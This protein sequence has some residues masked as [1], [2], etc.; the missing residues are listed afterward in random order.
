MFELTETAPP[1]ELP[2]ARAALEAQLRLG[3]G[4][5]DPTGEGA[6]LDRVIAAATAALEARLGAAFVARGFRLRTDA[7]GPGGRL[8]L[9]VGPVAEIA[10]ARLGGDALEGLTV[11]PGTSRQIVSRGGAPLPCLGAGRVAELDFT[12]GYGTAAEVPAALRE[13]VLLL[14]AHLYDDRTGV[15]A[16]P[17]LIDRLI[18]PYRPIRL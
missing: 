10:A 16:E 2:V 1:P 15:R 11:A 14:A 8:V 18:G 4:F 9:P 6:L 12:A 7:W 5:A 17:M 13:A 3:E